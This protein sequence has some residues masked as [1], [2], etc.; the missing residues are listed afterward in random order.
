MARLPLRTL[1][2]CCSFLAITACSGDV[3]EKKARAAAERAR[4]AIVPLDEGALEQEIPAEQVKKVQ[5]QL[6]AL[7]EYMGPINGKLDQV[8]LN[9]LEAFQR[10]NDIRA[11]GRFNEETLRLLDQTA[12]RKS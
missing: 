12:S 1:A 4:D 10:K 2:A 7:L 3:A 6:T 9:A 11:D 5:E 8:T